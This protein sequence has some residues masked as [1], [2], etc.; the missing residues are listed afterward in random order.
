MVIGLLLPL[1]RNK[2]LI[3]LV[4]GLLVLGIIAGGWLLYL[5]ET[6][7]TDSL[8]AE[9]ALFQ[10][11]PDTLDLQGDV[12][13]SVD[14]DTSFVG[15]IYDWDII[16]NQVADL[17]IRLRGSNDSLDNMES[18]IDSLRELLEAEIEPGETTITETHSGVVELDTTITGKLKFEGKVWYP[19]G[20]SRLIF[21][22]PPP[23]KPR[24][25]LFSAGIGIGYHSSDAPFVIAD[26]NIR[27]F[28]IG[29]YAESDDKF[30]GY[31]RFGF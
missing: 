19:S 20:R 18:Y 30:G 15:P 17:T 27:R 23:S 21:K 4:L 11:P 29:V 6:E 31:L 9:L 7:K 2:N 22:F 12:T 5:Q 25:K 28:G 16:A 1:L 14:V 13:D 8:Q 24:E 3:Y 26:I 10:A